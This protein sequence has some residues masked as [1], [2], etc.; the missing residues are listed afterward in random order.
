MYAMRT[1]VDTFETDVTNYV[2]SVFKPASLCKVLLAGH[3]DEI[4]LMMTD[5][6]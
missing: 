6:G 5:A 1:V 4:G 2:I 3:V